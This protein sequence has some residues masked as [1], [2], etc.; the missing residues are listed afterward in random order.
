MKKFVI[1][2]LLTEHEI[3][4]T[5]FHLAIRLR[6]LDAAAALLEIVGKLREPVYRNVLLDIVCCS[7]SYKNDFFFIFSQVGAN[8]PV[9]GTSEGSDRTAIGDNEPC[10]QEDLGSACR[11]EEQQCCP[12]QQVDT[13]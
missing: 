12:R 4:C 1:Q 13:Q 8:D 3:C 10:L 5:T 7:D 11:I 6:N 9:A 2:K